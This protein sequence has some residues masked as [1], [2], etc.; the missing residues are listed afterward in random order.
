LNEIKSGRAE[1]NGKSAIGRFLADFIN[2][3]IRLF[4]ENPVLGGLIGL[5][6][7][8]SYLNE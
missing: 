2:G 4:K 1:L 3:F 7:Y 8:E 6:R 5:N